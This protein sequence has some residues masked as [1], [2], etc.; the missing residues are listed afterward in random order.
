M[1][2]G[3][4]ASPSVTGAATFRLAIIG[5]QP[6]L[7][8]TLWS[9]NSVVVVGACR[10]CVCFIL[11]EVAARINKELPQGAKVTEAAASLD[12][13]EISGKAV[14]DHAAAD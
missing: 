13:A 1:G 14:A 6:E 10:E 8:N 7:N 5:L 9:T 11:T 4:P 2:L 12:K 3:I